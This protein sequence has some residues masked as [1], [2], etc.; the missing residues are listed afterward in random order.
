MLGMT[1]GCCGN[2]LFWER[3]SNSDPDYRRQMQEFYTTGNDQFPGMGLKFDFASQWTG[4]IDS[5]AL[6][7]F[8]VAI[9]RPIWWNAIEKGDWKGRIHISA[10]HNGLPQF[11]PSIAFL[12]AISG[13]TGI[14]AIGANLDNA[15]PTFSPVEPL[16]LTDGVNELYHAST[17]ELV[18]GDVI[19]KTTGSGG[20]TAN[21]P[22]IA[23]TRKGTIDFV[24]AGDS[25][26][27]L[28]GRNVA[29]QFQDHLGNQQFFKNLHDV[30]L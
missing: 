2:V 23:R 18:G 13:L 14:T 3:N 1:C 24:I 20:T 10:E 6:I 16:D 21:K 25:N 5:Y 29:G 8:P 15:N 27:F 11:L 30:E 12:N 26:H 7:L 4:E 28:L 19:S 17:S 9:E 22:W